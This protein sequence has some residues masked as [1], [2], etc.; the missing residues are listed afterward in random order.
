MGDDGNT[1]LCARWKID[2][3]LFVIFIWEAI[4]SSIDRSNETNLLENVWCV[5]D[6][7]CTFFAFIPVRCRYHL[8]SNKFIVDIDAVPKN[9][10]SMTSTMFN[11]FFLFSQGTRFPSITSPSIHICPW[12]KEKRKKNG[13]WENRKYKIFGRKIG[14]NDTRRHH[15]T[16]LTHVQ[17]TASTD[18]KIKYPKVRSLLDQAKQRKNEKQRNCK[19]CS[20]KKKKNKKKFYFKSPKYIQSE[21]IIL[22]DEQIIL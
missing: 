10:W 17:Q 15:H 20:A 9:I 3:R 12:E 19:I 22:C 6:K 21:N 7:C 16:Q 13:K 1:K 11:I 4:N 2:I 5:C 18:T 8:Q 14:K